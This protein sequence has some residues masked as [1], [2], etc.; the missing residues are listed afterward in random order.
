MK[1]APLLRAVQPVAVGVGTEVPVGLARSR[2]C[3]AERAA[4]GVGSVCVNLSAASDVPPGPSAQPP[5]G[6]GGPGEKERA[7]SGAERTGLRVLPRCGR[8]A[9]RP[10]FWDRIRAWPWTAR[11]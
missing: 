1:L 3:R 2:A 8:A 10:R 7:P 6:G 5:C 4:Y 9:C 11:R